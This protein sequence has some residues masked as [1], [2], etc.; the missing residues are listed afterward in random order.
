MDANVIGMVIG[1]AVFFGLLMLP[2]TGSCV[3]CGID[4]M[5]ALQEL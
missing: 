5:L 1:Y 2:L 3:V 4:G